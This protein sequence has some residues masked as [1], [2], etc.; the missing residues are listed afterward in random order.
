MSVKLKWNRRVITLLSALLVL[1]PGQSVFAGAVP[2]SASKPLAYAHEI[3]SLRGEDYS[4][5]AFLKPLLAGKTV[6]SLGEN[7]HRVAEYASLKTKMIKYLH[8]E[9]GFDVIAFE[10]GLGDAEFINK[11]ADQLTATQMMMYSVLPVWHSKETLEL[12]N[13]IKKSRKTDKPLELAGFD[14]QFTNPLLT[15]GVRDFIATQDKEYGKAFEHFDLQAVTEFYDIMNEYG[16]HPESK[17]Y[18]QGMEQVNQRNIP[19]YEKYIQF[20][21]DRRKQFAA[22]YPNDPYIVDVVLKSLE[23]RVQF[24]QSGLIT[25]VQESYEARDR[26][27][28]EHVEWLMKVRYPGKKIILWAHNDHLAKNT[29]DIRVLEGGKW[30]GSFKSM[31]ELLHQKLKDKMYVVGFFMNRGKTVSI[32]TMKPFSITPMPNGSLEQTIMKSGYANT[33][34]DLSGHTKAK[35][36][37]SWMFKP[38]YAAEDGM[39]SEVIA[40]MSMKFVPKEQFDGLMVVDKV[41]TPTPAY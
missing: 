41:N 38:I 24:L 32:T 19:E 16:L 21:K 36:A 22:A 1:L 29:S 27:M 40:P 13:Y 8:E 35:A 3:K 28:A 12:F 10:S 31:G 20:I 6:V 25:N 18:K 7:F 33:F 2:Q 9:L 26:A 17:E 23:D 15:Y 5:L 34:V 37:N 39:T 14:N 11:Q 4:D 30:V